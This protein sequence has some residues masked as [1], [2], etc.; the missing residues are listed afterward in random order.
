MLY[1]INK[2][3]YCVKWKKY[4]NFKNSKISYISSRKLVFSTSCP[5]CDRNN[6]IIFKKEE[7]N[8]LY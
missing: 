6:T 1:S 2:T 5:K 8:E 4:T 7:S 3:I